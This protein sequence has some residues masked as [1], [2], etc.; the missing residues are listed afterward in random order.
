M[1]Q[2]EFLYIRLHII[3]TFKTIL[4]EKIVFGILSYDLF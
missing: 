2:V 3:F 1:R 4:I